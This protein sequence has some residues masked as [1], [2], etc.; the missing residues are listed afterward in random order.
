MS[1]N[2]PEP[3]SICHVEFG[4]TDLERA[5]EFYGDLFG[6]TFEEMGP[7]YLLFRAGG[8]SGGIDS[9]RKTGGEGAVIVIAVEDID[10]MLREIHAA[11]GL[12]IQEKT[13]IADGYGHYAYFADPFG[14][15]LGLWTPAS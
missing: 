15:Q 13:E 3:G 8:L 4:A 10:A 9:E 5:K 2:G 12:T 6:W 14:N 7:T 11:G 1:G